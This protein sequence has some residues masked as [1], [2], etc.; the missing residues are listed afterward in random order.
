MRPLADL[1]AAHRR[2]LLIDLPGFGQ[3]CPLPDTIRNARTCADAL[4][5]LLE[6]PT[7]IIGHSFGGKVAAW[8]AIHHPNKVRRLVLMGASGLPRTRTLPERLRMHGIRLL[9][10]TL[11]SVSRFSPVNV[12]E[13]W[14]V[15]RFGSVDYRNAGPLRPLLVGTL[16]EDLTDELIKVRH[17]ALLLW[18]ERDTETPLEVG[19]RWHALLPRSQWVPLP[20]KGH[21]LLD[22][23][24]SHLLATRIEPFLGDLTK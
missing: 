3:S 19:K 23:L 10:K 22:Q 18:G 21:D 16:Q 7:D 2:V 1:L 11:K 13:Q 15:P 12:W 14:F 4:A 6:E 20:G 17:P 5:H 9:G 8:L 24:G